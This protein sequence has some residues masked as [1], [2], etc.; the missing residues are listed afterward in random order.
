MVTIESISTGDVKISSGEVCLRASALGSC[1]AVTLH[2]PACAAGA[3]AHVMLP[4]A[5][6]GRASAESKRTRYADDAVAELLRL[7]TNMD[8]DTS[9]ATLCL[10]GGANVLGKDHD[11]LGLDIVRSLTDIFAHHGIVPVA[12]ETGGTLRRSCTLDVAT[13]R[14]TFTVGDS[15]EKLLWPP[16]HSSLPAGVAV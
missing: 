3:M 13:G 14:V 10:V 8:A 11:T 2:D 16:A 1:V 6:R 15:E 5:S 4:G 9:R 12:T 7:M